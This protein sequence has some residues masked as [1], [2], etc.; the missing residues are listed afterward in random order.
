MSESR[1]GRQ[2]YHLETGR[3]S[4]NSLNQRENNAQTL[5]PDLPSS[6]ISNHVSI[7]FFLPMGCRPC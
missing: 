5:S 7:T 2:F 4:R 3:K 1:R 6:P